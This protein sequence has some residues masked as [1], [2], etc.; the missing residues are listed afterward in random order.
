MFVVC[1]EYIFVYYGSQ[2]IFSRRA[3]LITPLHGAHYKK[4]KNAYAKKLCYVII[5]KINAPSATLVFS[6]IPL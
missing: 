1:Q 3:F 4:G 6:T 2:S 5:C